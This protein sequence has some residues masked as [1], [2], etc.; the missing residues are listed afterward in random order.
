MRRQAFK[1]KEAQ[2]RV[3]RMGKE[4]EALFG[5]EITSYREGGGGALGCVEGEQ[6][7]FLY[8]VKESILGN[9]GSKIWCRIFKKIGGL[10]KALTTCSRISSS[11]LR[12]SYNAYTSHKKNEEKG[13]VLIKS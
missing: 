11:S 2:L 9:K 3:Q 1:G 10:F 4:G 8:Q 7:L 5:R 12:M 6:N 13:R